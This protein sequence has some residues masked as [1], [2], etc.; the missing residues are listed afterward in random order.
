[1]HGNFNRR[2]VDLHWYTFRK[3]AI[4]FTTQIM[5][6]NIQKSHVKKK[7]TKQTTRI[8]LQFLNTVNINNQ[9][10]NHIKILNASI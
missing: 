5:H 6:K 2:I 8:F 7:Q 4:V 10:E 9:H 1:V 3:M